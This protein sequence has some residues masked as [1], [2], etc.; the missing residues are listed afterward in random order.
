[1]VTFIS[2]KP[3]YKW[4]LTESG[5]ELSRI[6][7]KFKQDYSNRLRYEKSVPSKWYENGWV[8]EVKN[9]EKFFE[10]CD[11]IDKRGETDTS[12]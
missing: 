1:M 12:S 5:F 4:T 11:E 10:E 2:A 8:V 6:R 9:G 3:G 7:A